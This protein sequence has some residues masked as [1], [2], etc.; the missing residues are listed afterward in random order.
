M[1]ETPEVMPEFRSGIGGPEGD[2]VGVVDERRIE[3]EGAG[4]QLDAVAAGGEIFH[5]VMAPGIQCHRRV[6]EH[7]ATLGKGIEAEDI[8]AAAAHHAVFADAAEQHIVAAAGEY[9]IAAIAAAQRISAVG[10][11]QQV[12]AD[13]AIV[14][15]GDDHRTVEQRIEHAEFQRLAVIMLEYGHVGT[16]IEYQGQIIAD[17]LGVA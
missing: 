10:P 6:A 8:A 11:G 17:L 13:V 4:V 2:E 3:A 12:M 1:C 7:G 15:G 5:A 9:E 14:G 16:G